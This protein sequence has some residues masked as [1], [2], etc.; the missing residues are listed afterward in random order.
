MSTLTKPPYASTSISELSFWAQAPEDREPVFQRL[1]DE[2]PVSWQRPPE[3]NASPPVDGDGYWAV[4]RHSDIE[5]VSRTPATFCSG[6]GVAF[7]DVPEELSRRW[8]SFL[9]M[10]PPEHTRIRRAVQSVFTPRAILRIEE[11]MRGRAIG[12]VDALIERGPCD[13]VEHVANALPMWISSEMMGV[14]ESARTGLIAAANT[15]IGKLDPMYAGEMGPLEALTRALEHMENVG[16]DLAAYRRKTPG[17]DLMTK[18][19]EAES[20]GRRLAED[21]VVAA[22]C[23]LTVAGTETTR[24]T[25]SLAMKALTDFPDQRALLIED[26]DGRIK[27]AI[28]EFLRWATPILNIRRTATR[29]TILHDV[30]IAEGDKVMIFYS[31]GNRDDRVYDDPYSF[32]ITR[33]HN[34][35]LSFGG[36]GVHYCI[37]SNLARGTLRSIL[38]ELLQRVPDIAVHDP[39]YLVS[40]AVNSVVQMPCTFSRTK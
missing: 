18:L 38:R 27:P 22:F 40:N 21:E 10:D 32:D 39:Q 35:H 4:V 13:F 9:A 26:Y 19:V 28:E 33:E 7:D 34:P 36:P 20:E 12:V 16:R 14:P 3:G 29:D 8:F 30:E 37:G 24:N 6:K 15:M 11:I 5:A 25:T 1:R 2:M 17:D 23:V 31:S